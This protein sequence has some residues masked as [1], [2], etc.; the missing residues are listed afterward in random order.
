MNNHSYVRPFICTLLILNTVII[1]RYQLHY[2]NT[3]LP[4]YRITVLPYYSI[5]HYGYYG[6]YR[7]M[8]IM[9]YGG[10]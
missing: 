5:M 4:Y 2:Q 3:V 9:N 7:I 6:Y 10:C 1:H 8:C